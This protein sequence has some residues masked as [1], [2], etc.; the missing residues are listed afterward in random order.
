MVGMS[1][2]LLTVAFVFATLPNTFAPFTSDNS[3]DLL[4]ADR[5]GAHL[6]EGKLARQ[7][8]SSMLNKTRTEQFFKTPE[9]EL[10]AELGI[11]SNRHANVTIE[12][13]GSIEKLNGTELSA[14]P[15][16]PTRGSV[17]VASRLVSLNGE[18]Y[19][20]SVRIW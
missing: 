7:N 4:T 19:T 3:A 13:E 8:H 5:V 6:A 14:G 10:P 12:S 11:D 17:V 1:V 16:V 2:F 20:L 18:E 15:P 9:D